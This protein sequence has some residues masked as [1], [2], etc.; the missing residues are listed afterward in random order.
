MNINIRTIEDTWTVFRDKLLEVER[1][2]VP[3]KFRRVNSAVDPPWMSM[4]IKR[5]VNAKKRNY[6]LMRGN[7]TAEARV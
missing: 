1:T 4:E 5:A 6:Y 7:D 2:T 3:M